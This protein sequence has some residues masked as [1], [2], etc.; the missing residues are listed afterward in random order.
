METKEEKPLVPP[1]GGTR[2]WMV[3]VGAFAAQM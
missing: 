3:A 1:N 2:A